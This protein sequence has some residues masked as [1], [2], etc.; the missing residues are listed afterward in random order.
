MMKMPKTLIMAILAIA[1][2][3]ALATTGYAQMV[4]QTANQTVTPTVVTLP[5][6]NTTSSTAY[7]N[8]NIS[9]QTNTSA[10]VTYPQ[11]ANQTSPEGNVTATNVT[12]ASNITSIN[13]TINTESN[14]TDLNVTNSTTS[15]AT[16]LNATN[17]T[18]QTNS[19]VDNSTVNATVDVILPPVPPAPVI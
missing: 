19:T 17:S 15:N 13:S 8:N 12:S 2:I 11:A 6:T 16:G 10:V 18:V 1:L 4:N 9:S 14:V 7:N 5:A 3:S